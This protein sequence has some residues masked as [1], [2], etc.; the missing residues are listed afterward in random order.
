MKYCNVFGLINDSPEVRAEYKRRHD[1]IWPEMLEL[2]H[3]SG[4]KNYSIWNVHDEV[5][6]YMEC[7]DSVQKT[8]QLQAEDEVIKRWGQHMSDILIKDIDPTT[9]KA[10]PLTQVFML[11]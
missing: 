6:G 5:F 3:A 4:L 11:E 1:E 2:I 7:E 9:G 10:Y 8:L